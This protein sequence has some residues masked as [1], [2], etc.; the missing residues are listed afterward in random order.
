MTNE[1]HLAKKNKFSKNL[2]VEILKFYYTNLF[3]LNSVQSDSTVLTDVLTS[4]AEF[5]AKD[6]N[7]D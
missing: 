6:K 4:K 3:D 1:L 5:I 7:H 2:L